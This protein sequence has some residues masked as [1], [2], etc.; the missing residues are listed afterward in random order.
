MEG[1]YR[2]KSICLAFNLTFFILDAWLYVYMHVSCFL[3]YSNFILYSCLY[4][5]VYITLWLFCTLFFLFYFII[6]LILCYFF[7]S[8]VL[9]FDFIS[10]IPSSCIFNAT[11]LYKS[12]FNMKY[13]FNKPSIN[14]HQAWSRI[15]EDEYKL[16][17][18]S[19]VLWRQAAL[20]SLQLL[21]PLNNL[22]LQLYE[23]NSST[24]KRW[25]TGRLKESSLENRKVNL[26]T[27]SNTN[28]YS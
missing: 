1:N 26:S 9:C 6:S 13:L 14:K 4:V 28:M 7:Y 16:H 25:S 2:Q 17:E 18:F 3:S 22:H 8:K 20:Q 21:L 15:N 10:V 27:C 24:N 19:A 12:Y 11:G 23:T 5:N